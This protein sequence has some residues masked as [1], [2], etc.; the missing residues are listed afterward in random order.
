MNKVEG[1]VIPYSDMEKMAVAIG[2][3]GMFGKSAEQ[4]LPLMLI[5]QAQGRHP[6]TVAMDYDVIQGRPA[7]NSRATLSRFQLSGGRIEWQESNDKSCTAVFS[8]PQGGSI[9]ITWTIERASKAGLTGKQ[10][11]KQYPDQMLR[12]RCIAEGVRATFP[13]CLDGLYTVE[14][15][16]DFA[17]PENKGWKREP[18]M[19]AKP[20]NIVEDAVV[21]TPKEKLLYELGLAEVNLPSFESWLISIG[22]LSEGETIETMSE[23]M[24]Q[25]IHDNFAQAQN[26][27]IK[28]ETANRNNINA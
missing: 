10:T 3:N 17:K 11:W 26:A 9:T 1:A 13:A 16:Q 25:K 22:K 5:A 12:A 7:I 6:A 21:E 14:E 19:D 24:A 27:W 28:W 20:I 23:D 18:S 2:K 8:H 4:L 15:V